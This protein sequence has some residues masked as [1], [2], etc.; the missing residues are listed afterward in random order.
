MSE[1]YNIEELKKA[2]HQPCDYVDR[3]QGTNWQEWKCPKCNT[4]YSSCDRAY[5]P[6]CI[7]PMQERKDRLEKLKE[8]KAETEKLITYLDDEIGVLEALV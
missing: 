5:C 6:D 1:R 7:E 8:R 2:G 4:V 3:V